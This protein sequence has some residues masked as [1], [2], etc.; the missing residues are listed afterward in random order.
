VEPAE[1][2]RGM[3]AARRDLASGHG[4]AALEF[5][6]ATDGVGVGALLMD[7]DPNPVA[8]KRAGVA[9]DLCRRPAVRD[10][11]VEP[12]VKVTPVLLAFS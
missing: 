10:D 1:L 7:A 5:K 9:P 2:A 6:P 12:P 3:A 11:E 8:V 4:L